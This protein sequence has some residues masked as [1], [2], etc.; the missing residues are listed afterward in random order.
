MIVKS[1][2]FQL[3]GK[4]KE[5]EEL[6]IESRCHGSLTAQ[7]PDETCSVFSCC[8]VLVILAVTYGNVICC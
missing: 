7:D 3:N 8:F 5:Q 6:G 1:Q 2:M 4:F